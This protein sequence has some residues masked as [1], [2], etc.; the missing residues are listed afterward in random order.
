[1]GRSVSTGGVKPKEGAQELPRILA[2]INISD[3]I[4]D[5][6]RC[7]IT[8]ILFKPKSGGKLAYGYRAEI[9]PQICNVYH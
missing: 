6:L 3:Y 9:L 7:A 1:M 8:P 5:E 2:A 4:S